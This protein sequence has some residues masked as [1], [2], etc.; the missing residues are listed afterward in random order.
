MSNKTRIIKSRGIPYDEIFKNCILSGGEYYDGQVINK[1]LIINDKDN[2]E[3]EYR[4]D[5]LKYSNYT[6]KNLAA[7]LGTTIYDNYDK[8]T[9]GRE[10]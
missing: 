5:F 9:I 1:Q 4:N 6:G 3:F 2:W 8:C 10:D 7:G